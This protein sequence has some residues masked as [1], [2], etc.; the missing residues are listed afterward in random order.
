MRILKYLLV[1]LILNAAFPYLTHAQKKP[2][3]VFLVSRDSNNYEAH[4]TIPEFAKRLNN[5]GFSTTVIEGTGEQHAFHF[6]GLEVLDKADLLVVFCRRVAL[7]TAQMNKI[8]GY[9]KLGK[10]VIGIRTANHAFSVNTEISEGYEA[11]PEFVPEI[12]G[13]LNR[14]YGPTDP[15]TDVQIVDYNSNHPIVRDLKPANWHSEGNVYLVAPLLDK[16][17]TV[18]LNG[19]VANE[20]QPIAWTRQA[21]KSKVFYTSLGYPRDFD[22]PQFQQ[23]LINGIKWTLG[24]N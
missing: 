1:C 14:G 22:L 6:P 16:S 9:L 2:H 13:S 19:K 7:S 3:I 23:L 20:I 21:D 12:L 5:Q 24:I 11:W 8:K 18:L 15:G 4:R 17:A 10:P